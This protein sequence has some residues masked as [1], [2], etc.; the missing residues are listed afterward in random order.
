MGPGK[1]VL[2]GLSTKDIISWVKG[3]TFDPG[4]PDPIIPV[5]LPEQLYL[6]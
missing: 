2:A 6:V 5:L 1:Q 4:N 3:I